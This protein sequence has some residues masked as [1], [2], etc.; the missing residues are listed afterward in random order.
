LNILDRAIGYISPESGLKRVRSRTAMDIFSKRSG[1][2]SRRSYD[3]AK[4]GRRTDNWLTLSSSANAE[5]LYALDDLRDRARDLVRNNPYGEKAVRAFSSNLVGTG[6]IPRIKKQKGAKNLKALWDK[7]AKNCDFDEHTDFSGLQTLIARTLFESGE[8]LILRKP[9]PASY[10]LAIPMQIQVLE[11]DFIDTSKNQDPLKDGGSIVQGIE[12]DKSGRRVAYWLFDRHPGDNGKRPVSSRIEASWVKHIFEK[13]RPGQIRGITAFASVM[14]RIKDLSDYE[15]AELFSKKIQACFTAF[16]TTSA[17]DE[18]LMPIS[19]DAATGERSE[20]LN[21]GTNTYLKPGEDV[22]FGSPHLSNTYQEYIRAQLHAIAAGLGL[23]YELLTGDLSQVNYSSIRAGLIE[24][25]RF[26]EVLR[27]Q[28]IVPQV[29]E[30]V[31]MWF[32]NAAI[33]AGKLDDGE[34]S[35]EWTPPR[36][37]SVDPIKDFTALLLAVRAGFISLPQAIASLGDDK[38]TVLGEIAD[39][40]KLLDELGIVLDSDPRKVAKTGVSQPTDPTQNE[41]PNGQ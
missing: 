37:E 11:P 40:N 17:G 7:F 26:M 14:L 32:I 2:R 30:G 27:W 16:I 4:K 28:I 18:S 5:S 33:A 9:A 1:S 24:F 39:S 38:D 23:T 36:F 15:E 31:W 35:A 10:K 19:T 6:I 12:F 8:C 21:P 13:K 3:A 41:V 25:R 29:C 20:T 34:Y 22:K